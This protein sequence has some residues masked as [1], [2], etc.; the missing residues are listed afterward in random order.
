VRSIFK[1]GAVAVFLAGALC[2]T[3]VV[4]GS[5]GVAGAASSP[6][7]ITPQAT[8]TAVTPTGLA[9]MFMPYD[10]SCS[11]TTCVAVGHPCTP[12]GCGGDTNP[13]QVFYSANDGTTWRP[14]RVPSNIGY[15]QQVSCLSTKVCLL[16]SGAGPLARS[17]DGGATWVADDATTLVSASS[18]SC[19]DSSFCMVA[20]TGAHGKVLTLT[21]SDTGATWTAVAN[22][23]TAAYDS[24]AC[25]AAT[26]CVASEA[27]PTYGKPSK[28]AYTIDGGATWSA[29][30]SVTGY[31]ASGSIVCPGSTRC[32]MAGT[33]TSGAGIVPGSKGPQTVAVTAYSNDAGKTW[34]STTLPAG[35]YVISVSCNTTFECVLTGA[36]AA[37]LPLIMVSSDGGLTWTT[38]SVPDSTRHAGA[39]SG[40]L[41]TSACVNSSCI[42]GGYWNPPASSG[43]LAAVSSAV[44]KVTGL[45]STI[46]PL[47]LFP[48]RPLYG[49]AAADGIPKGAVS[50]L[51]KDGVSAS[52]P[53]VYDMGLVVSAGS[54]ALPLTSG[55]EI[56]VRIANYSGNLVSHLWAVHSNSCTQYDANAQ[57]WIT[58]TA[59]AVSAAPLQIS[60]GA[61]IVGRL[62]LR[63]SDAMPADSV[64]EVES[65]DGS[66]IG[67]PAVAP[68]PPS[69]DGNPSALLC[70][71]AGGLA[72]VVT[73]SEGI[74]SGVGSLFADTP[75]GPL[76]DAESVALN[77]ETDAL[78]PSSSPV[79]VIA[80]WGKNASD[81]AKAYK[82]LKEAK[83]A[84]DYTL[85]YLSSTKLSITMTQ[86]PSGLDVA[87]WAYSIINQAV[88]Y[89][90][91]IKSVGC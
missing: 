79:D 28:L 54:P 49:Q 42:V 5:M 19:P 32:V 55:S 61:F 35:T 2:L 89:Y 40:A 9:T 23:F 43:S 46:G 78:D 51:T 86:V 87:T 24:V 50:C 34:T 12:G 84:G 81:A 20:G 56:R 26:R 7:S 69:I 76:A 6:V 44:W 68:V 14:G 52:G 88:G 33:Q 62:Y 31:Q 91:N 45:F 22:P 57:G 41:M 73:A 30:P 75:L 59:P 67:P 3:G 8:W 48:E 4:V 39:T 71:L 1:S 83:D 15:D 90:Q 21:S 85:K 58:L 25:A 66:T 65:V 36:T 82:E 47:R 38:E 70:V 10:V 60:D 80:D 53:G 27:D 13:G 29:E 18:V 16:V 17:A 72:T 63:S 37:N 74:I 77:V 11:G 64:I